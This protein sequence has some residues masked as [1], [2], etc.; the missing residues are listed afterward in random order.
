MMKILLISSTLPIAGGVTTYANK[1]NELLTHNNNEVKTIT[2]ISNKHVGFP[3]TNN[4][5]ANVIKLFS[6]IDMLFLLMIY[7]SRLIIFIRTFLLL[8]HYTPDIIHAQ[9]INSTNAVKSLCLR[10]NLRLI[11]T[12]HSHLYDSETSSR[13][14][15][16]DF[17]TR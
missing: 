11:L 6:L 3:I 14:I 5:I 10:K 8:R 16:K 9:D 17:Y 1:L 7:I 4:L 12:I 15:K 13:I 2:V